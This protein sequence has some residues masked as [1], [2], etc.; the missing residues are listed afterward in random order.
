MFRMEVLHG[1][2]AWVFCMGVSH[3]SLACKFCMGVS[4]GSFVCKFCMEVLHG[5][6][7]LKFCMRASHGSFAWKFGMGVS[8]GSF[9]CKFCME[10][11]RGSVAWKCCIRR[12]GEGGVCYCFLQRGG[13]HHTQNT[14]STAAIGRGCLLLFLA[15]GGRAPH[16]EHKVGR[17]Y[18]EGGAVTVSCRGGA[19]TT[20]R[21]QGRPPL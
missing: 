16:P 9:V 19:G 18:R 20:P 11:L 21:T 13:G 3:R 15:E 2:F 5:S 1:S 8:H 10:V 12:Y 14:R 6:F 7:A 17:R 4:H